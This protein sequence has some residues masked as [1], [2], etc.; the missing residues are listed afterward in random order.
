MYVDVGIFDVFSIEVHVSFFGMWR[1]LLINRSQGSKKYS[2]FHY[3]KVVYKTK[4][5]KKP[6]T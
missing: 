6:I 2:I 1:T 5:V 4:V 3:S